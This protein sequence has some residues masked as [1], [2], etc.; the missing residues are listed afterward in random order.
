ME[1][2][3][4]MAISVDI[5]PRAVALRRGGGGV[6]RFFGRHRSALVGTLLIV[7]CLAMMTFAPWLSP[8]PIEGAGKPNIANKLLPPGP[9][10]ALGTDDL[11]RDLLS[12]IVYGSRVSVP[13]GVL[14]VLAAVIIGVPLGALAGYAGGWLD[15]TIMR[16]TDVFLG[17]PPLLLAIAIAAALGRSFLNAMLAIGITWWP[18][19]ARLVRSQVV[20]IRHRHYVD[21]A[22]CMGVS[23]RR[24]I[25]RHVLPNILAPVLVQGS[26]DVGAAILAGAGLSFLGLGVGAPT[27]DWGRILADGRVIF[28]THWW[29]STFPGLSIFLVVL[30]FNLVGDALRD[31]FDP[32]AQ[33]RKR[34]RRGRPAS[35]RI[36]R[37]SIPPAGGE[38]GTRPPAGG[39][40]RADARGAACPGG[41]SGGGGEA[42]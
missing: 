42:A 3:C 36:L 10:H 20:S 14:V 34:R 28:L 40:P 16:V 13:M 12:R 23:D 18:W 2:E 41:L 38:A 22:R 4:E 15:E 39:L 8:Y 17:F 30:A 19:Y 21:A 25:L 1:S 24:I 5:Q 33:P 11:G 29:V 32:R 27:A 9:G 37:L 35:G 6:W 7:G 26:M 31:W